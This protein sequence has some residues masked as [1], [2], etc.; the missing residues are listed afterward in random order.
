[1]YTSDP[2]VQIAFDIIKDI[3][4]PSDIAKMLES[5]VIEQLNAAYD[6]GYGA[7]ELS[8]LGSIC[9]DEHSGT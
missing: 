8:N 5:R 9:L 2:F 4:F 6:K 7:G 3:G 1:M